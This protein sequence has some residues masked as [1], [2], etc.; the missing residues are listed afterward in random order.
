MIHWLKILFALTTVAGY[1]L[2]TNRPEVKVGPLT[3]FRWSGGTMIP[4]HLACYVLIVKDGRLQPV[5]W[6]GGP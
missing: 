6:F 1:N 5:E 2:D 3:C 4:T